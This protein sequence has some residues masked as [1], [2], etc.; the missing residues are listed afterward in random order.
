MMNRLA[1]MALVAVLGFLAPI[2]PGMA[3]AEEARFGWVAVDQVLDGTKLGKDIQSRIE[4]YISSRQK[5]IDVEEQELMAMDKKLREQAPLLSD[6]ARREKESEFRKRYMALSDK[7]AELSREIEQ[8]RVELL[9]EF[10]DAL[11]ASVER[12]AAKGGYTYV[13][14]SGKGGVLLYGK[15]EHDLTGQVI[16]EL[17]GSTP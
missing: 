2:Q 10:N 17:D 7:A 8:K 11:V 13:L 15:P 3:H 14:D 5:V 6:D 1:G 16:A 12:V 9:K 4:A